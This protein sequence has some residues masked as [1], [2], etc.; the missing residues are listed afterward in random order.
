MRGR[1]RLKNNNRLW[2]T[3]GSIAECLLVLLLVCLVYY[4]YY[5][6]HDYDSKNN[7]LSS[8]HVSQIEDGWER[9]YP[10]GTR[11]PFSIPS[12]IKEAPGTVIVLETTLP[13]DIDGH[14]WLGIRIVHQFVNI[15]I[16]GELR[17]SYFQDEDGIYRVDIAS[18]N[19][20]SMLY[21]T[22]RGKT[23]TLEFF[24]DTGSTRDFKE[25]YYGQ[26]VG[27]IVKY[28][29]M[30]NVSLV[31]SFAFGLVGIFVMVLGLG[32]RI[33]TKGEICI[34]YIGCSLLVICLWALT[35][36]EFRDF[37]FANIKGISIVPSISL[38]LFPIP[39]A[40]YFNSVTHRRYQMMFTIYSSTALLFGVAVIF[41]QMF[42]ITDF[43]E[44]LPAVFTFI[45]LLML[46]MLI[47][48]FK[49]RKLG[50]LKEYISVFYGL[51]GMALIGLGQVFTFIV[52]TS[53]PD[54]IY[55]CFGVF[56]FVIFAIIQAIK[57]ILLINSQKQAA[58]RTADIKSRFLANMSHEIR[59]PINA[60]LGMNEA[61]LREST[62]ENILGYAS[63]VDHAGHLL[64]S[65]IN[66]I[67]DFSKLDSGKM[68]LVPSQYNLRTLLISTINLITGRAHDKNLELKLEIDSNL[69]LK[70]IG[71]EVRIQQVITNIL[72]N[73]VKYTERGSVTLKVFGKSDGK[74][75]TLNF[76]VTDTGMGI[77]EED[78]SRLFSAFSRLDEKKNQKIEGTGLG[79]AITYQL[80]NLMGGEIS[81][82]S[83]YGKGSTFMVSIPQV[84]ADIEKLGL[85][86]L[87]NCS[88][89]SAKKAS[90]DLF[91]ATGCKILIVDDV[92]VNLKVASSLLKST[93]LD[94]DSAQSGDEGLELAKKKKYDV[95]LLDHMMPV[96]DGIEV[97][98]EMKSYGEYINSDTPVIM[99]TANAVSGAKEEYMS[100]GFADYIS[101][102]FSVNEMQVTLLK[103]LP[104][105]K[106]E[107]VVNHE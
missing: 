37:F 78:K 48:I 57:S 25:V 97:F 3:L 49:D 79:L 26:K 61:I 58:I 29:R 51:V 104:K 38:L 74:D 35:Q 24:R 103:Y 105:E 10:D 106:V 45:Y 44:V 66:D 46:C 40:F 30:N 31:I 9:V 67:L 91:R 96:K 82:D 98:R 95:I 42:R 68:T 77:K 90:H 65:L 86:S 73:A 85:I 100:E 54:G 32:I 41:L 70:L 62:E 12:S 7:E 102:P 23:L 59:T 13:N 94:I 11:K 83:E 4:I 52:K 27:I 2:K 93:G 20:Y 76:Y 75:I 55:M 19:K 43:Y 81:I 64:L 107:T 28:M 22:D 33:A 14:D 50:Y 69:P 53:N 15:Y 63:D 47:C 34:D 17:D 84:V 21:E 5:Q 16:D 36:S 39:L 18:V 1:I 8:L 56:V 6:N 80:V 71:D 101:K 89:H 99:L 88:E 60:V 72:T 87:E 92:A